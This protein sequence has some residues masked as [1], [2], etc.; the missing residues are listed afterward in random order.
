MLPFVTTTSPESFPS[1]PRPKIKG[2]LTLKPGSS[3]HAL[4]GKEDTVVHIDML[5]RTVISLAAMV[6]RKPLPDNAATTSLNTPGQSSE[7]SPPYEIPYSLRPGGANHPDQAPADREGNAWEDAK[8]Q[9][10]S[11]V[12]PSTRPPGIP[13]T[14]TPGHRPST[15]VQ[16]STSPSRSDTNRSETN[17][18]KRREL[19]QSS[20]GHAVGQ[21]SQPLPLPPTPAFADL[22]LGEANTNP[23]QPA[24]DESS[25]SPNAAASTSNNATAAPLPPPFPA[26][27]GQPAESD[28]WQREPSPKPPVPPIS[29]SPALISISSGPESPAWDEEP[30]QQLLR[31]PP[32]SPEA[33]KALAEDRNVWDDGLSQSKNVKAPVMTQPSSSDAAIDDWSLIDRDTS[34][35]ADDTSKNKTPN[36]PNAE[37]IQ[38]E[39]P[40]LPPRRPTEP[41][42]PR[43]LPRPVDG[44]AETYQIKNI[45][46][47]DHK[48]G[49]NPRTPPILVQNENGPCPLVALVNALTLT[50]PAELTDTALVQVLRSREQI[51]L[52]LLLDAVF[53]ELMSSRRTEEGSSLPDVGELY[54][55]LKGLHT[56]MNVNPRFVPDPKVVQAFKRTSLTHLHPTERSDSMPGT[57]EDTVE[58]SLYAAFSIPLIHGWLPESDD[59]VCESFAR[60][61]VSYEDTQNILFREEE[62]EMKLEGD[63][64]TEDEQQLYQDIFSIKAFLETS[65]TQLTSWGLEVITKA[66]KPGMVAIL[67]RNDHFSTL[68][69]HPQTLQLLSLVT[70]AG[71]A[72]HAEVVWE[73][74]TDVNGLTS[75]F[76]SGDFRV[77]GGAS[78]HR[79]S[80]SAGGNETPWYD[81]PGPSGASTSAGSQGGDWTSSPGHG[82]QGSNSQAVEGADTEQE[83]HDLALALQLQEEENE[84]HRS[85]QARRDRERVL[86][87]QYIEQQARQTGP[88]SSTGAGIGAG[89]GRGTQGGNRGRGGGNSSLVSPRGSSNAATSFGARRPSAVGPSSPQQVR[90]LVP[91]FVPQRRAPVSRPVDGG[92]EDAPPTYEQ[93]Q[94][95]TPYMP[96]PGHPSHPASNQSLSQQNSN[97]SAQSQGPNGQRPMMM[98]QGRGRPMPPGGVIS[99]PNGSRERDCVLM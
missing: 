7:V 37:N 50:T 58:M 20:S 79:G 35:S 99:S 14:L 38:D 21:S 40:A 63:G 60:Q 72:T 95:A 55:F 46:W 84:R 51:S 77:V 16:P 73:S 91:P 76:L 78:N 18:F 45:N 92:A 41:I 10:P 71:Y 28:P 85:E 19:P 83:D 2:D 57:F 5:T 97:V 44:K 52:G 32:V 75:E 11:I 22:S 53:D 4:D 13:E 43:H 69:R 56:G 94:S 88:A 89:R 23:W 67:F 93:A 12:E 30:E 70:D 1:Q 64:L 81:T 96:P 42:P 80:L 33:S 66:M 98:G 54:A 68:Y 48:A 9:I 87:E 61:A 26:D 47:H 25:K 17:P 59:P 31:S 90:P 27:L 74:L 62:L 34:L 15:E 8:P 3:P 86:S 6:N 65:A 24:L 49:A 82:R 36:P 39:A 29:T